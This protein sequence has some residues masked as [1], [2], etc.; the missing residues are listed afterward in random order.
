MN[1]I[2]NKISSLLIVF[3]AVG[4]LFAGCSDEASEPT[5]DV[6]HIPVRLSLQRFDQALFAIDTA[7]LD[8]GLRNAAQT[9]PDFFPFFLTE[10]VH[11]PSDRSE[12]PEAALKGFVTAPQVRRLNDSCQAV[13]G[14][15]QDVR[16]D[17]EQ[18][19]RFYK[20]YLPEKKEPAVVTAVT[21]FIGDAYLV[22]DTL[23]ML[24]LD[25]F[26]GENFSGYNP[27][28]FPQYLR[29]QFS[30][31]FLPVKTAFAL[32]AAAIGPPS[33]DRII[34]HMI[35][36]GKILYLQDRLIPSVPDSML[37]GYTMQEMEETYVNEQ[38]VW[39][40]LLDMKVLYEPLSVKNRKIVEPGP[41]SDN[42]FQEAPGQ[43][44][45]WIGW[46]IVKAYMK[47][48]PDATIKDLIGLRDAQ[49]LMEQAKYKPK[50]K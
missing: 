23:L 27:E 46:Q 25:F 16:K 2:I 47:R 29:R 22:N 41:K 28:L 37:M 44:G 10:I 21:E 17:L 19:F 32:S 42:V 24:G 40:R 45:N 33:G 6:S 38:E 7:H 39:A 34:D 11:D 5:P 49:Q 1:R 4:I 9:Y 31:E 13:F 14:N 48:H 20:Y 15:M 50:R 36:N 26:L 3:L 18:L 35:N 30:K 12:N 43:I 8:E